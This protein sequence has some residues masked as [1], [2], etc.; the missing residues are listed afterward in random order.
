MN[1]NESA[2]VAADLESAEGLKLPKTIQGYL[3]LD[4]LESAEGL[5]LPETV[6]GDLDLSSLQ[7]IKDL[8]L[9]KT[10]QGDLYLSGLESA[11]KQKIEKQNKSSCGTGP[12]QF[13]SNASE[14]ER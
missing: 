8:Q 14:F 7:S 4:R 5:Q 2:S 12:W 13:S 3:D 9:P 1:Y 6:Q 11:E 10:I